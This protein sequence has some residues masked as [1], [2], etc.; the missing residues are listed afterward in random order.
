MFSLTNKNMESANAPEVDRC[1]FSGHLRSLDG[2]TISFTAIIR[3]LHSA[4]EVQC[5]RV[6]GPFILTLR[7]LSSGAVR[8]L[9]SRHLVPSGCRAQIRLC[10]WCPPPPR[11]QP[12]LRLQDA[13]ARAEDGC[14]SPRSSLRG[15]C[16]CAAI[17]LFPL[18][19]HLPRGCAEERQG[20]EALRGPGG[21]QILQ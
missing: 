5:G 19:C 21:L 16:A 6:L 20:G 13:S 1:L 18:S 10:L 15:S 7:L 8:T 12:R 3:A 9:R 14:L 11:P 4:S 17:P 2:R